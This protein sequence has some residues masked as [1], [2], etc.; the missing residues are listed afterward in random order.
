MAWLKKS[1]IHYTNDYFQCQSEDYGKH[2]PGNKLSYGDFQK[3]LD[4]N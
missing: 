2:E 1:E 4:Y 3:Y